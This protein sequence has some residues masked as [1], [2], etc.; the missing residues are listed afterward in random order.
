MSIPLVGRILAY[1]VL[2]VT[3]LPLAGQTPPPGAPAACTSA[4]HHQFDF[5]I[6]AWDVT[7]PDGVRAGENRIEPILGGC[8]LQERWTG[9]R[10]VHGSSY[11]IY[12]AT[13][14]RWHQTWVDEG[15]TL[16]VLEGTFAGGRMILEGVTTDTAGQR[17]RQRITWE[18]TAPGRV[19]QLWES[20]ADDGATWTVAFDGRYVK[21]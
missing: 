18:Q 3:G 17:Q 6:G 11:N 8:V 2:A 4:E 7:R 16:L 12:D 1:S 13:R 19:R 10:G 9:A 14:R 15:G 20:S 5:W 21:R